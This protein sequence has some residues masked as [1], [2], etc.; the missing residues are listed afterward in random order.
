MPIPEIDPIVNLPMI[1]PFD[2]QDR[3]D[4]DAITRNV[5]KWMSAAD[6]GTPAVGI[7]LVGSASGEE[8]F[9]NENDK[10]EILST[11]KQTVG[12]DRC[13]MGGI[14]CPSVTETLKRAEAFVE[15]GAEIVRIRIPRYEPVV[16]D[17]FQQVVPRCPVP[18]LLMHQTNPERFGF[19]GTP[20]A[21]P[22]VVGEVCSM[23]G[24]FGYTTDHDVRYE[25]R[26]GQ[27]IPTGKRFWICNGSLIL[28]GTL[29][30]C[31]GTTTAFSNI[32]PAA[33]HRLLRLGMAGEYREA[34]ELQTHIQKIDAI[35]LPYQAAGV[36]AA[37]NLLGFEGTHPRKP[38]RPFPEEKIPELETALR[39]AGLA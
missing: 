22:E 21:T 33:L 13:V 27:Q 32:W 15:R 14:D 18:I 8:W 5:E 38:I 3:I 39:N 11:V 23:D 2:D 31:N 16:L 35:M 17:Y 36:K 25:W 34:Q 37:M 1:T 7:F 6:E 4:H 10:L 19:A 26:V 24:V 30:G 29:I 9:L 12:N 20:A 28:N